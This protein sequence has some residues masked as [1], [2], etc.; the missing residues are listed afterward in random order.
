M[1]FQV[2]QLPFSNLRT[3]SLS[4]NTLPTVPLEM[5][6][7]MS[8]L[9]DLN[10]AHNDLTAIP[11]VVNH[12]PKLR[13]LNLAGNPV[14]SITNASLQGLADHLQSLDIT[15]FALTNIEEEAIGELEVLRTLKMSSYK[16]LPDFNIPQLIEG[17][18]ALR[19][20][21][22]DID[23]ESSMSSELSG[24]FPTKVRN[25]TL[26]GK[27][28]HMISN[29]ALEGLRSPILHLAFENTSMTLLQ[30]DLFK[31]LGFVQNVSVDVR[32][33]EFKNL[34]NPSTG[35]RP[36]LPRKTFLTQLKMSNNRWA[37]NCDIG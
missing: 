1:T 21:D 19:N 22:I 17:N 9:R 36:D 6:V 14:T 30:R 15:G 4:H 13:N 20:L 29:A 16:N 18:I 23:Y 33:N 2:R 11:L 37:C 24:A 27:G 3:L 31:N 12:L 25:I 26:S 34:G 28:L 8:T 10:L 32:N 7:N 5:A 35:H